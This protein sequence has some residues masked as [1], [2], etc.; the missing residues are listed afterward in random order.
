MQ[1]CDFRIVAFQG[2][3]GYGAMETAGNMY[4]IFYDDAPK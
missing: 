4:I 3:L 1:Q 2:K